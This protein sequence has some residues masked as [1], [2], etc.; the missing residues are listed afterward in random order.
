MFKR[1]LATLLLLTSIIGIAQDYSDRWEGYFSYYNIKD[2][3]ASETKIYAASENAVFT[4][5]LVTQEIQT[6]STI[7]GLAGEAISTIYYSVEFGDLVIGYENGLMEII[8]EEESK[9]IRVVDIVEKPT[10]PPNSK[11]INHINEYEGVLYISTN[12]GVSVY[13]LNRLEFGDT[14]FIGDSGVQTI[15]TQTT[16]SNGFIFAACENATGLKRA[17][18]NNS[19]LIDYK[20]WTKIS[21]GNFLAVQAVGNSVYALNTNGTIFRVENNLTSLKTF[22]EVPVDVKSSNNELIVTTANHVYLYSSDFRLISEVF[23]NDAYNTNYTSSITTIDDFFIGSDSFGVLKA[24]IT[25]TSFFEPILPDGPLMNSAFSVQAAYNN[26]WVTYG[27]YTQTYNPSP[28][29]SSGI[30]HLKNG[31]WHNIPKDSVLN[32]TNLNVISI[33]PN[34]INQVFISSFQNGIL[35]VNDD[36]PTVLYNED[37]SGLEPIENTTSIRVSASTFDDEGLLWSLTGRV[38]S[39]LKSYDPKSNQWK[40]YS[41]E[42]LYTDGLRGEWGFSDIAIDNSGVVWTG[43]YQTGLVGYDYK[44]GT[45]KIISFS[46]ESQNMPSSAVNSIAI[47]RSNQI[48]IGTYN[49]LRVLYNPSSAFTDTNAQVSEIVILDDGIPKELLYQ[50]YITSIEVDGSNNKWIGTIGSGIFYFSSDGQETIYHFTI[51]NSPLPSNNI[52]DVSIDSTNGKVF[53]A[54]DKGLVAFKSGSSQPEDNY[55]KAFVYP[56]P[57]RPTFNITEDMVKIKGITENVNIKI[58]DVEG[59]LVAEAQSN[60]NTRYKG[61]NLEID[62]GTAFW[63]GKN[64]ANRVVR[65]GVYLIMLSDT[66]TFET[67]VLKLMIIR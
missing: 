11:R 56:N 40:S 38:L 63:N 17:E 39:P 49:G 64:L 54:T 9:V 35:E 29:K 12:Y 37:N 59:N 32:A 36:V 47:D 58:T 22:Q 7:H 51:D 30:S 27:D 15:V 19:N 21:A 33:N 61:Y 53:I 42:G 2:V 43:G 28:L 62:G 24:P 18:I 60:N 6:L 45:S 31:E 23:A 8:L 57:V 20:Q 3:A 41:F 16:V 55:D 65:S 14:Y 26:L 4:Y 50:E 66:R 10:I 34:K 13:D 25:N 5:D 46:E 48:W 44:A 52:I 67:K 1:L